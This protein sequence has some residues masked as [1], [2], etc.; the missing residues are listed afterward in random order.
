MSEHSQPSPVYPA[1]RRPPHSQQAMPRFATRPA[2][3]GSSLSDALP[4]WVPQAENRPVAKPRG[5]DLLNKYSL[6]DQIRRAGALPA[7]WDGYTAEPPSSI[8]IAKALEAVD[9]LYGSESS[10]VRVMPL[11]DGGLSLIAMARPFYAA[12]EIDNDGEAAVTFSDRK[13]RQQVWEVTIDESQLKAAM[14]RLRE[15]IHG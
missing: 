14:A 12:L 9:L 13:S 7:G 1:W 11:A 15:L 8:A 10:L 6:V 2:G 4:S 5:I 3:T